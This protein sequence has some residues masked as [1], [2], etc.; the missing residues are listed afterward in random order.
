MKIIGFQ[1]IFVRLLLQRLCGF[2]QIIRNEFLQT[3]AV[4]ELNI[5]FSLFG[6]NG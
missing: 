3:V 1:G 5:V 6:S 4:G 2:K